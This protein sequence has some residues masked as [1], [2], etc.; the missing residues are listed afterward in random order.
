MASDLSQILQWTSRR[1]EHLCPRQVLGARIGLAGLAA[2]GWTGITKAEHG[3]VIVE[4]DG[5]FADGIEVGTGAAVGHRT[6]RVVDLGKIAATFVDVPSGRG[7]RVSPR[8]DVRIRAWEYAPGEPRHYFA[9]LVGYQSMPEA[10][11]LRFQEVALSPAA[12]NI[13]SLPTARAICARCGEE[14]FNEREV[15]SEGLT[16]C[17]HCA[18]MSYY[19]GQSTEVHRQA[20]GAAAINR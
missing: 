14:I 7:I 2:F 11:L 13:V 16:L 20:I 17:R 1:H 12:A 19:V 18:G 4:T 3:F 10:E 9:Q 5:C 15:R 8:P 6:L